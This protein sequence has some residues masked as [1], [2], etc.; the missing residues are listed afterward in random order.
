M[1]VVAS[2]KSTGVGWNRHWKMGCRTGLGHG[3]E[4]LTGMEGRRNLLFS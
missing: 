2:K 4:R 1:V 3:F